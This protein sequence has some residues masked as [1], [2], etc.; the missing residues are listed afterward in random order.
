VHVIHSHQRV[1]YLRLVVGRV[2]V[3][4]LGTRG[5]NG[6]GV[7]AGAD[8]AEEGE[9]VGDVKGGSALGERG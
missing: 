9:G 4:D 6:G 3:G 5:S 2:G 8:G 1:K 7:R